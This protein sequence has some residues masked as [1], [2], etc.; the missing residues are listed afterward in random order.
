MKIDPSFYIDFHKQLLR[1]TLDFAYRNEIVTFEDIKKKVAP[2]R[3]QN[4]ELSEDDIYYVFNLLKNEGYITVSP[5]NTTVYYITD[6][7]RLFYLVTFW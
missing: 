2:I 7:G 4:K 5:S 1:E 3:F 6:K